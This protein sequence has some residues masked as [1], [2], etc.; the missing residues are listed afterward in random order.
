MYNVHRYLMKQPKI[1]EKR[2]VETRKK[3]RFLKIMQNSWVMQNT[4][5]PIETIKPRLLIPLVSSY[6]YI[7]YRDL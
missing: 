2:K 6:G 5:L 7:H 3:T 1:Q 4:P